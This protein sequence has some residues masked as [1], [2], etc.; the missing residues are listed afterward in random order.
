VR[1]GLASVLSASLI[2]GG[3]STVVEDQQMPGVNMSKFAAGERR[4]DIIKTL[5]IPAVSAKDGPNSCD[6][7]RYAHTVSRA[8]QGA[9][10]VGET[11]GSFF[12]FGL[13]GAVA[14]PAEEAMKGKIHTV[15]FCYSSDERLVS[16]VEMGRKPAPA[17]A[18][19]P[20]PVPIPLAQR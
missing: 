19:T 14:M 7:Y 20:K 13:F 11:A 5:G 6:V 10:D 17:A 16:V 2:V 1:I 9:I 3:C 15:W 12:T 8:G 4:I 18:P